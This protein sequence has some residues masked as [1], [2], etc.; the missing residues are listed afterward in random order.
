[1]VWGSEQLPANPRMFFLE[2]QWS[3]LLR[4]IATEEQNNSILRSLSRGRMTEYTEFTVA[5]SRHAVSNSD[6][7][8]RHRFNERE[9]SQRGMGEITTNNVEISTRTV[10]IFQ[11]HVVIY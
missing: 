7:N 8:Q 3:Y 6:T 10:R 5:S 9:T 4:K 1:M 2:R 11:M